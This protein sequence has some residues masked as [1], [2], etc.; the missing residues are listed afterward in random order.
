MNAK[1]A[2][3]LLALSGL[4]LVVGCGARHGD[5]RIDPSTLSGRIAFSAATNDVYVVNADGSEL[6]RLTRTRGWDF[7]PTWSPDGRRIAFRSHRDGNPEIYVMQ[8]DGSAQ[9]NLSRH[10]AAD[11]GPAWAPRGTTVAFNSGRGTTGLMHLFLSPADRSRPRQVR[12]RIYVEYPDWSPDGKRIAFMSPAPY[13]TDNYEIYVM[14]VD[15]SRVRRLTNSPGPDGWPAW[16]PDGKTI[17]FASTRDD[18]SHSEAKDCRTTGDIGPFEDLYVMNADGSDQRRLTDGFAQFAAWSPDSRYLVYA[19]G[20]HVIR[21]D[22]S[23]LVT[24]S[25]EGLRGEPEMPDWTG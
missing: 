17:A 15:G 13:G 19:P 22:G 25:V 21:A 7:D 8:A 1:R 6:R 18:C 3:A 11:W 4:T 12:T 9:R 23:G 16:S 24:I 20:L 10:H 14:D 5:G 2:A